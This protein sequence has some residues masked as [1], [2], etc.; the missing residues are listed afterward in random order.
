MLPGCGDSNLSGK[1]A[2]KLNQK[3]IISI[4]FEPDVIEKMQKK[5]HEGVTYKTMDFLNLEYKDSE[6]DLVIDK[7]SFD[8]L[9]CD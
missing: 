4:D 8:A 9:C 7:G 5:G 6:F 2:E 1:I 3:N